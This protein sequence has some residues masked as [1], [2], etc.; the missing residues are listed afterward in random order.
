[1]RASLNFDIRE[2]VS[3]AIWNK[4]GVNS[5]WFVSKKMIDTAEFY[6][7]FWFNYY[8]AKYAGTGKKVK[9]V[10]IVINNWHTGGI[11]QYSGFR[12]PA[13]KEGADLSQHRFHNAFDCDIII[14]FE[15]GAK[16]EA[17]YKEIH[18]EIHENEALFLS[19]GITTIED[20]SIATTWLHTDFRY[21]PN[22]TE[23]F[24]VKL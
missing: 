13:C 21:I 1:M 2:F 3:K 23:I 8:S 9:A 24:V 22:Q 12:E 16:L 4:W 11:K 5:T 18:K 14:V 10:L 19:K 15:D 20:V 6:K 17:D 7:T